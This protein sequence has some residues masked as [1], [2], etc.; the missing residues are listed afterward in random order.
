MDEGHTCTEA[1]LVPCGKCG[2]AC[3][4]HAFGSCTFRY[5]MVVD[6]MGQVSASIPGHGDRCE[7]TAFVDDGVY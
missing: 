5:S 3:W 4:N 6:I 7:C 1:C 2:H